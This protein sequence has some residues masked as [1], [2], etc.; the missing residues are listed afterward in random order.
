MV[1]LAGLMQGAAVPVASVR[2]PAGI[3]APFS[4]SI[5][6]PLNR[7]FTNLPAR[8]IPVAAKFGKHQR[9]FIEFHCFAAVL[10]NMNCRK[11]SFTE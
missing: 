1:P 3:V 7:V 11:Y 2:Y 5:F 8:L 9:V 4:W 10:N 6:L